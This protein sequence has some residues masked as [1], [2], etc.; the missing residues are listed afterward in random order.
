MNKI[1][2]RKCPDC[3]LINDITV[4][5]CV[6]G[7]DISYIPQKLYETNELSADQKGTFNEKLEFYVQKC[8]LCGTFNY[9]ADKNSPVKR[10]FNCAKAKISSVEPELYEDNKSIPKESEKKEPEEINEEQKEVKEETGEIKEKPQEVE[11]EV[12]EVIKETA[13]VNTNPAGAFDELFDISEEMINASKE[14]TQE[15]DPVETQTGRNDWSFRL[16]EMDNQDL[17]ETIEKD[18]VLTAVR[19]GV[20]S[21]TVTQDMVREKPYMLGR[22]A[23]QYEFLSKDPRVSGF[24]CT[25]FSNNGQWYIQ[26]NN[27]T[28]G[29]FVDDTDLGEGGCTDLQD[30][31]RIKLGHSVDSMEFKVSF[32]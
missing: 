2:G 4:E 18:I 5:A 3:G 8:P 13:F 24:H 12:K 28:N 27:S 29:T 32:E 30:G 15:S 14:Y 7:E 20:Y 23:G 21:F 19:Y 16:S 9:T 22:S 17:D 31:D 6:C 11:E 25:L 10:C 1:P 26:D